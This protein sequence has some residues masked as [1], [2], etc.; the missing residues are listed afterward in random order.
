MTKIRPGDVVTIKIN[1]E[2]RSWG[3]NPAHDGTKC[4][5][6]GYEEIAYGRT[7]NCCQEPGV[8]ENTSWLRLD[9]NGDEISIGTW[10]V[11]FDPPI[12]RTYYKGVRLRDLPETALWEGDHVQMEHY[13]GIIALVRYDL[14]SKAQHTYEIQTANNGRIGTRQ[15]EEP[16]LLKRGSVWRYYHKEPLNL[17]LME[18]V[19]L[20]LN[21]GKYDEVRSN[22]GSYVWTKKEAEIAI[23]TGQG[24]VYSRNS[25]FKL[26]DKELGERIRRWFKKWQCQN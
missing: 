14:T 8:Y 7:N 25:V 12:G 9:V 19:Q 3:F 16:T 18:E 15:N 22:E 13:Q 17:T 10:N 1:P 4:R 21:I 2:N 6:I 5:V 20:H 26:H 23:L 11:D 24:D